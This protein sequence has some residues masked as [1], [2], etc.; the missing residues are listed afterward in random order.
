MTSL[1]HNHASL[2]TSKNLLAFSAGI[3]SSALFFMLIEHNIP[4]DLAIVNYGIRE[5]SNAEEAYA[6][7][8]GEKYNLK[9]FTSKAPQWSSHFEANARDFRY[10]FFHKLIDE[11][12]YDTLL[13]AHQL[14]DQLEWF[15]MRLSK[16][17]GVSELLGLQ[18]ISI[19]K[20]QKN[21]KYKL[22][23]PLL[24]YT[25]DELLEY[26]EE[27]NY[28][29]YVDESNASTKY[30]RNRFRKEW[31]DPLIKQYA[32]GIKKSFKYLQRD[33]ELIENG[34]ETL[35]SNQA[36]RVV[37]LGREELKSRAVDLTLKE[38][39]YL[40]SA[41]QR[42]EIEKSDSVVIGGK[43]AVVYQENRLYIAPFLNLP[44]PKRFKDLCRVSSLPIKIR[45]YCYEHNIE[46]KEIMSL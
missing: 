33:R 16:G 37:E 27:H 24:E 15:L 31:S 46:P 3:D 9:V 10:D 26:L 28:P 12:S 13:T 19:R 38:L 25:K 2:L 14:N 8:L 36:L 43:W 23:R 30:E 35:Y 44:M 4:F 39:G 18:E 21:I 29:Y 42:L 45:P 6:N 11:F 1:L 32:K 17:A 22:L 5:Q 34:I 7:A 20:T 40:L 41:S